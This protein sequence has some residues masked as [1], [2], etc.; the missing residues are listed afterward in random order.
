MQISTE[1]TA[2]SGHGTWTMDPAHS[3]ATFT[4]RHMMV[5]NVRGELRTLAG[6]AIFDP[7]RPEGVRVEASLDAA[8]ID[9]HDATRDAHLRSADFFDAENHP[10]ITFVSRETRRGK[11]GL[12]LVGDLTIRGTTREVILEVEGPTR[13]QIDPWG[14]ARVGASARTKIRRSDFGMIWNTALEAG[15]VLVADEVA[16]QI[17]VSLVRSK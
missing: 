4:V 2:R 16:I 11:E 17:E 8:S 3:S 15:G 13:E 1:N 9:T 12:E 6:K 7:R 10:R 5:T 14:G